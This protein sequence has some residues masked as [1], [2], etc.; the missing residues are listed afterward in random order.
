MQ[1]YGLI[2]IYILYIGDFTVLKK[3]I[4]LEKYYTI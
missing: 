4:K 2:S 3:S 1:K